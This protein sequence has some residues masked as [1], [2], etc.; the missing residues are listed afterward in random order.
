M[1]GG[2]WRLRAEM[3]RGVAFATVMAASAGCT[4]VVRPMVSTG[5]DLRVSNT[6]DDI[7]I[8]RVKRGIQGF[9]VLDSISG[10]VFNGAELLEECSGIVFQGA[11]GMRHLA[12]Q[13]GRMVT[14]VTRDLHSSGSSKTSYAVQG[15]SLFFDSPYR[16]YHYRFSGDTLTITAP[17]ASSYYRFASDYFARLLFK[18]WPN[19][20]DFEDSTH[21]VPRHGR[22]PESG[23]LTKS[24]NS[25]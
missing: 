22:V 10:I 23:R 24:R 19:N 5:N 25:G 12:G 17:A 7:V 20:A 3:L 11:V 6:E 9:Y 14:F 1:V 18:R 13:W 2:L 8:D 4:E 16:A 15:D 21:C